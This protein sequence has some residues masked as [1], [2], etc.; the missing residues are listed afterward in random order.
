MRFMWWDPETNPYIR[1]ESRKT[2]TS[3]YKDVSMTVSHHSMENRMR[4]KVQIWFGEEK[5]RNSSTTLISYST[6][7]LWGLVVSVSLIGLC[8]HVKWLMTS[9]IVIKA[10]LMAVWWR[11]TA[12]KMINHS[13]QGSQYASSDYRYFLKAP[14]LFTSMS[15]RRHCLDNVVAESFSICLRLSV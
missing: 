8:S 7:N 12:T 9:D 11:S 3:R 2:V 6:Q 13:V 14:N 1:M 4:L 5:L 15:R 10:L